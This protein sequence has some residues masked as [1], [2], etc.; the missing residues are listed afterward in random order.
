MELFETVFLLVF[1]FEAVLQL[2]GEQL[3]V[4][5]LILRLTSDSYGQLL[6][7][8]VVLVG[9]LS[10]CCS[11]RHWW[12]EID[13]GDV[14]VWGISF[15]RWWCCE[16][17]EDALLVTEFVVGL[18]CF[19]VRVEEEYRAG[20]PFCFNPPCP[21]NKFFQ[22]GVGVD[23]R[24]VWVRGELCCI[25]GLASVLA[26]RMSSN[27]LSDR[28][29]RMESNN[30]GGGKKLAQPRKV[31]VSSSSLSGGAG[32]LSSSSML[33]QARMSS[34]GGVLRRQSSGRVTSF[35]I[36]TGAERFPPTKQAYLS[37]GSKTVPARFLNPCRVEMVFPPSQINTAMLGSLVSS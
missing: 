23:G 18:R 32:R 7:D 3:V 1:L 37:K 17:W 24:V 27:G 36:T 6:E 26:A 31:M 13:G 2:L 5:L 28:A 14:E 29:V 20:D 21:H 34:A 12:W 16:E 19:V 11:C 25:E 30:H 8:G 22:S 35:T 15:R 4:G 10:S 33:E 9:S